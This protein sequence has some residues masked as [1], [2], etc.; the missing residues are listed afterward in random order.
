MLLTPGIR[1]HQ[2]GEDSED[3]EDSEAGEDSEAE[4][5]AQKE[6]ELK[7]AAAHDGS[8]TTSPAGIV[9]CDQEWERL[10]TIQDDDAQLL[11]VPLP[12]NPVNQG[13]D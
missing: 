8:S 5:V 2:D 13:I 10:N 7:D 1:R 3:S 6:R 11:P 9:L 4:Q 12:P